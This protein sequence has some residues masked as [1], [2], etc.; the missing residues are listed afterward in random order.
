MV[1]LTER[2]LP[3]KTQHQ[4][5]VPRLLQGIDRDRLQWLTKIEAHDI[6]P[7]GMAGGLYIKSLWH[8]GTAGMN[9]CRGKRG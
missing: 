4:M 8:R 3:P 7:Q 6:S 9:H 1:L 5:L 2:L